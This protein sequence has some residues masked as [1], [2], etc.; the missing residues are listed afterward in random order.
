MIDKKKVLE[1]VQEKYADYVNV[2][3][4]SVNMSKTLSGETKVMI[5]VLVDAFN[6][7]LAKE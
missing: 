5:E 3:A 6:E 1:K 4:R 2:I 7:E